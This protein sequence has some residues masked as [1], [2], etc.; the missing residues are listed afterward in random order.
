MISQPRYLTVRFDGVFRQVAAKSKVAHFDSSVRH[1]EN[2]GR[3]NVAR[4]KSRR[5][6]AL[7]VKD[8]KHFGCMRIVNNNSAS[9]PS[10]RDA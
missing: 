7:V 6:G 8:N 3:L 10:G 1:E 4:T 2:V 5:L 9:S